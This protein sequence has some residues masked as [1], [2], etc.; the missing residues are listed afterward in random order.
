[1]L[2]RQLLTLAP[3]NGCGPSYGERKVAD[4]PG[5]YGRPGMLFRTLKQKPLLKYCNLP[6]LGDIMEFFVDT[7]DT[8]EI[9]RL[10]AMGLV[11]G[12]TTNPSLVKKAGR[13][14][15]EIVKEIDS[16][17]KGPISVEVL[18]TDS[19]GM[20]REAEEYV[21]WGQN[22]VVKIP[23]IPE[24]MNAVRVLKKKGIKTNVTLVFSAMQALIAAKAGATYVSPFV[25]RVDDIGHSGMELV[26]E[27]RAIYDNYGFDTK[28]LAASLRHP[29]H[30]LEAAFIGA[31]VATIP[32]ETMDKLF[33]HP[34]TD[35]G[36][37]KFLEDAKQ[38]KK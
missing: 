10:A 25:G 37:A 2:T 21:K 18:A 12:V 19:A 38:W 27:I 11:D 16:L 22:I 34:L 29:T 14:Y 28:I 23:M 35:K 1:M 7:A 6:V 32:P 33:N 3:I 20:V 17:V 26:D 9:K 36:L 8:D 4:A 15:K 30:V 13:D 24:G 31:D 5:I